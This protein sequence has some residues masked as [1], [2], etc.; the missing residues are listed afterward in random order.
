M[1]FDQLTIEKQ[2]CM[3][4]VVLDFVD[5]LLCPWVVVALD[6]AVADVAAV[7]AAVGQ[8]C[9]RVAGL[10]CCRGSLRWYPP[11]LC[12]WNFRSRVCLF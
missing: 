12:R 10:S 7:V 4:F 1:Y 2:G 5:V 6:S 9:W 8:D 11:V 3:N